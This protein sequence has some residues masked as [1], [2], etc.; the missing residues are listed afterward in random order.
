MHMHFKKDIRALDLLERLLPGR[1][2]NMARTLAEDTKE[3]IHASWSAI[4]PSQPGEAPAVVSGE[5]D[6][7]IH[8]ERVGPT[9]HAV[10]VEANHG[11]YLEK[12]TVKMEA[13]PFLTPAAM[14][15]AEMKLGS[16]A[17][18]VFKIGYS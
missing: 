18:E 14:F 10:V 15:V 11:R 5:L 16:R 8:V 17:K 13:R 4:S 2:D 7:S 6:R 3:F 9:A 1:A 12:G